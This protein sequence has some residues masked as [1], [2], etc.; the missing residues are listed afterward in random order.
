MQYQFA[1]NHDLQEQHDRYR[2]A[3]LKYIFP[4]SDI[5]E[6]CF[7]AANSK[8]T[9]GREFESLQARGKSQIYSLYT[10]YALINE[11]N[12]TIN[13]NA[14]IDYKDVINF[15]SGAETSRDRMRI[16][17]GGINWDRTDNNGRTIINNELS[18]GIPGIWGALGEQDSRASRSGSGGKFT[19][20]TLDILRLQKMPFSSL[21]LIKNQNQITPYI[22]TATEQFQLG[23]IVNV[24]GYPSAEFVGDKGS[25]ITG[26]WSFPP[27]PVSKTLKVPLS[28]TTVYDAL[29]FTAFYDWG[30]VRRRRPETGEGKY[31]TARSA[32][33]GL[34]INLIEDFTARI[35]F[36]WP[37][38]QTPSD[39]HHLH[40]WIKISKG[41]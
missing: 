18:F 20:N 37:I 40:T 34:R 14:G 38:D 6:I 10:S 28:Q 41:F 2:L 29:R 15:Q 25:T 26:E 30:N 39:G 36:A 13:L 21:L 17:K 11:E 1:E 8:L 5:A 31:K 22:L 24:R 12:L 23:G 35:D 33:L 32:G 9:L 7:Y 4:I 3:S 16:L 27:Y 19:K